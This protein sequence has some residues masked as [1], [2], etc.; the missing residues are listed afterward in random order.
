MSTPTAIEQVAPRP[1]KQ[2]KGTWVREEYEFLVQAAQEDVL[3]AREVADSLGRS[4]GAVTTRIRKMMPPKLKRNGQWWDTLCDLLYQYPDYR[5]E[6]ALRS[7]GERVVTYADLAAEQGMTSSPTVPGTR[8]QVQN[9]ME[10]TGHLPSRAHSGDAGLDLRYSGSEPLTITPETRTLARTGIAVAI[11]QGYAGLICPRS[12]L[13]VKHGVTVVNAPGIIDHGYTGE[14]KVSLTLIGATTPHTIQPGERIAQL[15]IT[16][17]ATPEVKLVDALD[18]SDRGGG[19]F[20][21]TGTA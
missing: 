17:A 16:P 3:T 15:L 14:V 5:W 7:A 12:G 9:L 18:D 1:Q 13:A 8:L 20:G 6:D 10:T 21:S 4:P 2:R 19:G 11:P